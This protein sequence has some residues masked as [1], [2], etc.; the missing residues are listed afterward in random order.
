MK[1]GWHF[2]IDRTKSAES[3]TSGCHSRRDAVTQI[4]D[5]S[6]RGDAAECSCSRDGGDGGHG[7]RLRDALAGRFAHAPVRNRAWLPFRLL[8]RVGTGCR[9]RKQAGIGSGLLSRFMDGLRNSSGCAGKLPGG[10]ASWTHRGFCTGAEATQKGMRARAGVPQSP[11]GA[12]CFGWSRGVPPRALLRPWWQRSHRESVNC[13]WP[14]H[15]LLP[16]WPARDATAPTTAA[17]GRERL[18]AQR[19]S[20]G[21]PWLPFQCT[22]PHPAWAAG[23]RLRGDPAVARRHAQIPVGTRGCR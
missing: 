20:S 16:G 23:C 18:T 3:G 4:T 21:A 10:I 1:S 8:P 2:V 6:V 11:A 17:M 13:R 15:G 12:T 7:C 14:P 19:S 22:N 5:H 9:W